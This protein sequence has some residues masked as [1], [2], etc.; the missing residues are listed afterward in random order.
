MAIPDKIRKNRLFEPI[1]V[2][3]CCFP[4]TKT[5]PQ[6][7]I[8]TTTV[9]TAVAKLEFTFSMPIF[10][11][12]EV[13]AAN[14]ADNN[15]YKT[16]INSYYITGNT[17][18]QSRQRRPTPESLREKPAL[19]FPGKSFKLGPM[20]SAF[21]AI[22]GRPSSG[23]S[24][25]LNR[26]TGEKVSIVSPTPQTTRNS[27]RGIL[28]APEGQL[29]FVDTPGYHD[30]D[31]KLNLRLKEVAEN[32]L[33]GIDLILY[34]TDSIRPPGREEES[35]IRLLVN[36]EARIF[37]G[38]NKID[39]PKSRPAEMEEFV[40]RNLPEVPVFRLSG[41]SGQ[42]VDELLAALWEGA[43]EGDPM[44][45][46]DFYTDQEPEFRIREI[47]REKAITGAREELP[48]AVYVEIADTEMREEEGR[49]GRA[50][51][52]LWVRAF[53]MVER[54]SQK[55]IL[56]GKGGQNIKTIRLSAQKELNRIFPYRVELDLRVKANP[57]WKSQDS[58]LKGQIF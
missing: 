24:T 11:K 6:D 22:I 12:I 54:E 36:R 42:G 44:Y 23:K 50:R 15:A 2:I 48:H 10:A 30:S 31:K 53:L 7:M 16:H 3:S 39:H 56:V 41:I 34:L 55:G 35:I 32:S 49:D 43:P 45:P 37:A 13:S 8:K 47:I 18:E 20:K 5:I 26:I 33:D 9:R 38:V 40:R 25:L 57:K 1:F 46:G 29:V 27:I 19:S 21:V 4:V 28:T 14:R 51:E 17:V 58:L 52:V